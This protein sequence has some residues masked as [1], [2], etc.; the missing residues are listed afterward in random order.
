MPVSTGQDLL[1]QLLVED[2]SGVTFVRNY[3]QLQF[4]PPPTINVYPKCSVVSGGKRVTFGETAFANAVIGKIG[5]QV[6]T[7]TQTTDSILVIGFDDGSSIEIPFGDEAF[8]GPEAF[9]F[10]GNDNRW[11]VWPG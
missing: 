10:S 8:E 6:A 2:L 3:I 5:R 9:L 1:N 7:V 11:G 4:N